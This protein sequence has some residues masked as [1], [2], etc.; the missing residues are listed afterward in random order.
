MAGVPE[1]NYQFTKGCMNIMGNI[2]KTCS[3]PDSEGQPIDRQFHINQYK[4]YKPSKLECSYIYIYV[5]HYKTYK[6]SKLASSL[7]CSPIYQI[8]GCSKATWVATRVSAQTIGN[9]GDALDSEDHGNCPT[10]GC[11]IL[12]PQ[13]SGFSMKLCKEWDKLRGQTWINMDKHG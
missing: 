9:Q 4:P 10:D 3:E 6:P 5:F 2:K 13:P 1:K 12:V 7:F 11:D 8:L